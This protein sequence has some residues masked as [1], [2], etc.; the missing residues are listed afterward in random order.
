[1]A[2][3]IWEVFQLQRHLQRHIYGLLKTLLQQFFFCKFCKFFSPGV[4]NILTRYCSLS[5]FVCGTIKDDFDYFRWFYP[6]THNITSF[7][8]QSS[9]ASY[10]YYSPAVFVTQA[11]A[12]DINALLPCLNVFARAC[13]YSCVYIWNW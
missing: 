9:I 13:E 11:W 10:R 6:L 5:F 2:N 4:S 3:R 8:L 1:M 7:G 12:L